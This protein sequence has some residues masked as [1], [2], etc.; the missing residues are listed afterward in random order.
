MKY[1]IAAALLLLYASAFLQAG[2]L[3]VL[4]PFGV[5]MM[6]P[7][8]LTVVTGLL[9]GSFESMLM[10]FLYG[11]SADMLLGRTL[12]LQALLYAAVAGLLSLVNEKLYREKLFIQFAFSFTAAIVT[13]TLFYLV[14]FLLRGYESF[15]VMFLRNI[16]PMALC[17]G[18]L[19]L[20][21]YRP[22]A[23]VYAWLDAVDRKRNRIGGNA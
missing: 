1:R 14:W 11:I 23:Q 9:R 10:G 13:E 21:L 22:V 7:L 20:P 8:A 16:L 12:G 19:V 4:R 6:L 2:P 15:G 18:L 3:A 5:A 17:N